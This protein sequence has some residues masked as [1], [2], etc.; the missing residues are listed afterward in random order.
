ML[1]FL[2]ILLYFIIYQQIS[3]VQKLRIQADF[4]RL[5]SE[6]VGFSQC[7]LNNETRPI[8]HVTWLSRQP[9]DCRQVPCQMK[10][11]QTHLFMQKQPYYLLACCRLVTNHLPKNWEMGFLGFVKC[12]FKQDIFFFHFVCQSFSRMSRLLVGESIF[13]VLICQIGQFCRCQINSMGHSP[14]QAE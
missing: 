1:L 5:K 4:K 10:R 6:G 14:R 9:R 11:G 13:I 8:F 12:Q 7:F 3:Y 2:F